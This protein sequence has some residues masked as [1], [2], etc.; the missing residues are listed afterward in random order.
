MVPSGS[1]AARVVSPASERR[2]TAASGWRA[3]HRG[4][5]GQRVERTTRGLGRPS[6]AAARQRSRPATSRHRTTTANIFRHRAI[7]P[8]ASPGVPVLPGGASGCCPAHFARAQIDDDELAAL[9]PHEPRSVVAGDA[10]IDPA[11]QNIVAGEAFWAGASCPPAWL[12]AGETAAP[13]RPRSGR[14][15]PPRWQLP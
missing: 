15:L 1:S 11:A 13:L 9:G 12:A 6:A 5:G 8:A 4:R 7:R 14:R 10:Q 3:F 2:S